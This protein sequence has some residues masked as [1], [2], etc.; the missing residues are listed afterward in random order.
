MTER[1]AAQVQE[2]HAHRAAHLQAQLTKTCDADKKQE[3]HL[4]LVAKHKARMA[5]SRAFREAQYKTRRDL[6]TEDF[7]RRDQERLDEDIRAYNNDLD[8]SAT[9]AK[10][11][12][13]ASTAASDKSVHELCS[14]LVH[15]IA[16]GA[17]EIASLR[18]EERAGV[19]EQ[20]QQS[21]L[22]KHS[23]K[24][25]DGDPCDPRTFRDHARVVCRIDGAMLGFEYTEDDD[26]DCLERAFTDQTTQSLC[27]PE[28]YDRASVP[29][30][31]DAGD[32]LEEKESIQDVAD[33]LDTWD[34]QDYI[35]ITAVPLLCSCGGGRSEGH[36]RGARW[37][38]EAVEE[39]GRGR[40]GGR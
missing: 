2:Y 17:L 16:R 14:H 39:Y 4:A 7:L 35:A 22:A 19:P 28:T 37:G 40:G 25:N 32:K 9:A 29:P 5:E 11:F 21:F 1:E 27:A 24:E 3:E 15:R 33:K 10:A 6:D 26:M 8:A 20:Q 38:R 30:R 34:A 18:D 23:L 12:V 36:H 13:D 31:W